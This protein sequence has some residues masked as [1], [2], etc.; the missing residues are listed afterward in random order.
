MAMST[1]ET[2]G[3]EA[4]KKALRLLSS[5]GLNGAM[6]VVERELENN[7]ESWE[8]WSAKADILYFQGKYETALQCC[9]TALSQNPDNALT[10]NIK[11]NILYKLGRYK[12]AIECYDRAIEL[13]PLL[14]RAWYNKKLASELQLKRSSPTVRYLSSRESRKSKR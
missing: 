8:A 14:V 12:E 2:R 3:N 13:E 9:E 10:F 5:E 7:P 6:M 1:N 11:G 4:F